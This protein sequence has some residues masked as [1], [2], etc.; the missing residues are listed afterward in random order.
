MNIIDA[1]IHRFFDEKAELLAQRAGHT[2][3][4]AHLGKEYRNLNI[5]GA[6]VMGNRGLEP[7]NHVYPDFIRYCIGLDRRSGW[8]ESVKK[9]YDLVERH[10]QQ[11]IS[12][13]SCA[14][15]NH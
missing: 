3:N 15:T 13:A 11:N 14:V 4:E 12:T 10:L 1:H 9:T 2:N 5:S 6:V 7:E 8:S